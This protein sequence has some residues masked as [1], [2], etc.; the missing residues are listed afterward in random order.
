MLITT[1]DDGRIEK[2]IFNPAYESWFLYD[3]IALVWLL[4][5]I[6]NVM[7]VSLDC[8]IHKMFGLLSNTFM[9]FRVKYII[10]LL[11]QISMLLTKAHFL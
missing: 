5:N 4:N 3:Q 11:S 6:S 9:P 7:M 8:Y 10:V 2:S 1:S